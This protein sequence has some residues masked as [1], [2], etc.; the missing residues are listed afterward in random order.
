MS[1]AYGRN[2]AIPPCNTYY[3][4]IKYDEEDDEY[5]WCIL[6]HA[7]EGEINCAHGFSWTPEEAIKK[8]LK[9][10]KEFAAAR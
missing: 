7:P 10:Y 3:L 6:G 2:P 5:Y 9:Y 1:Y 8:A 4:D